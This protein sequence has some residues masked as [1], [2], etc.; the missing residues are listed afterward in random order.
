[1]AQNLAIPNEKKELS[2]NE[3]DVAINIAKI[4]T[5]PGIDSI[6]NRFIKTFWHIVRVPLFY[7]ANCYYRNR[8]L[9]ENF[10]CAKIRL[11]PKKGNPS[12][13]KNWPPISLLNCFYKLISRVIVEHLGKVIDKI[14]RVAQK[15][16]SGTKYFRR[17]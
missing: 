12:L 15:G 8:M 2:I 5:A 7:Y 4:D 9:T 11:K 14:T 1:M 17:C 10:C 6:S 3:F 13:L 16:F